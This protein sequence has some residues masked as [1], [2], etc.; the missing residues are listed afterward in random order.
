MKACLFCDDAEAKISVEHVLSDPIWS[1]LN[2]GDR[3]LTVEMLT[4]RQGH[5]PVRHQWDVYGNDAWKR[6]I[7]CK[8][9]NEGWMQEMD[10][11]VSRLVGPM[12]AGHQTSLSEQE[13]ADVAVWVTKT[14]LVF[15]SLSGRHKVVPDGTY[16][17]FYQYRE[18]IGGEPI[19]LAR[20]DGP[21]ASLYVRRVLQIHDVVTGRFVGTEGVL[22]TII[23]G[24]FIM[25]TTLPAEGRRLRTVA[26]LGDDRIGIWPPTGMIVQWPPQ[27]TTTFEDLTSFTG[28]MP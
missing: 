6:R 23:V 2:T 13:Q 17:A 18:P 4:F 16:H 20:Y 28:P 22:V 27:W 11:A 3:R 24:Q 5:E 7:Y 25:Q 1:H 15:E 10:H 8:P 9:C 14:S 21:E 19:H 26:Y 12:I